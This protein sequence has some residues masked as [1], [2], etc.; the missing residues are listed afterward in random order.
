MVAGEMCTL[1]VLVGSCGLT[2]GLG[3]GCN[4]LQYL[5]ACYIFPVES[6]VK[7][8]RSTYVTWEVGAKFPGHG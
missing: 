8:K 2:T 5:D 7:P 4:L 3:L 6:R 1:C